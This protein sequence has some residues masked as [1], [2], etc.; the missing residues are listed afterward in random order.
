MKI[1]QTI[2]TGKSPVFLLGG[3][4]LSAIIV[5]ACGTCAMRQFYAAALRALGQADW[6]QAEVRGA[7]A[8]AL[9]RVFFLG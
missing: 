8:L 9:L 1:R 2:D 4:N 7:P 3:N 5:S 6:S